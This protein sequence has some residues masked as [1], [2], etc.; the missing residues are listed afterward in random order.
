MRCP[1][2]N[3][4]QKYKDGTRC[5]QCRYQ[6]VFRKKDYQISDVTL[7]QIIKR[8][9]DNGQYAFTATQLALEICRFW[10]KKNLGAVGC[11]IIALV[12]SVIG[13]LIVFGMWSWMG[14]I[15]I[16]AILMPLA[17][18]LGQ[19]EKRKLSFNKAREIINRYHQ[20]HPINELADGAAF[21]QQPPTLDFQDPHYAPERILVVERDDLVDMLI[22]NRFHLTAKAAVVSRTGYPARV[23]TAC[24][25]FLRNHPSTPVQ[26]LHDASAQGFAL[27]TQLASDAQW[28][29]ARQRLVDLGISRTALENRS[30]LPWLPSG[31]S[32]RDGAFGG[33]ATK[34]LRTGCRVPLDYVG[35]KP[36]MNLLSAA[37]VAGTLLLAPEILNASGAEIEIDYG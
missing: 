24:R 21:R 17:L 9:S 25:E 14:G 34:R 35:P 18:W 26:V 28:R 20:A 19:R 11:S 36:M 33:N 5:N 8:L 22:R 3:H 7:R 10:R 13:G 16:L 4:N 37:V 29:F 31:Q 23:F 30:A 32:R 15:I 2:C 27:T 6:F 12:V 1:E